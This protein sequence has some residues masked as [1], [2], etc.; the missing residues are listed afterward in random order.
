MPHDIAHLVAL[1]LGVQ[2]AVAGG[3]DDL[4][5]RRLAAN[6]HAADRLEVNRPSGFG[7][8]LPD[9]G[10]DRR[11]SP[12][13]AAGAQADADLARAGRVENPP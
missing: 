3:R 13:L 9:G 11:T 6:A 12:G 7:D 4:E 1:H 5:Q 10:L 2:R 8:R